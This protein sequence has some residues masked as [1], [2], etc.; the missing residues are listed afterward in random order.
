MPA[1]QRS[2]VTHLVEVLES[3][4]ALTTSTNVNL[5]IDLRYATTG[6]MDMH[7]MSPRPTPA[8]D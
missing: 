8:F 7:N 6:A 4:P 2:V 5:A 3:W 1:R